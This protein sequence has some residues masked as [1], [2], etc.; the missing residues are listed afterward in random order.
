MKEFE[1]KFLVKI[2]PDISG[3]APISYERYFTYIG[4][5]G[6]VRVQKRGEKFEIESVFGDY[7]KKLKISEEAFQELSK[8]CERVIKRDTY[9]LSNNTKLKIYRGEYE[10]L[11]IVDVEFD[12][13]EEFDSFQKPDW[14]GCEITGTDLGKDGKIIFLSPEQI[15]STIRILEQRDIE[16]GIIPVHYGQGEI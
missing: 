16:Q 8:G 2:I 5:D 3:I 1:R 4:Q 15:I 13:K 9:P 7:R 10:G 12:S 6:Q 11:F 14:L